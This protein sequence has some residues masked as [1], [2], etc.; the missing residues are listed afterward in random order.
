M[1]DL[2]RQEL[3]KELAAV[4]VAHQLPF[5]LCLA[6]ADTVKTTDRHPLNL[7]PLKN[8]LACVCAGGHRPWL[9]LP[10]CS[11]SGRSD[12]THPSR[13]RQSQ[14]GSCRQ[15]SRAT[16]ASWPSHWRDCH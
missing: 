16:L 7:T 5:L 4:D 14:P 15:C 9:A 8:L 1:L 12:S 6:F 13:S 2:V 11:R 10:R 3:G